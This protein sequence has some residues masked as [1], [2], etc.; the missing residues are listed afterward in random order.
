MLVCYLQHHC[1]GCA[2]DMDAMS[3]K[4]EDGVNDLIAIFKE[5]SATQSAD[6]KVEE[7]NTG[8]LIHVECKVLL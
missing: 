3:R 1:E 5:K 6:T 8:K 4:V 2:K 7:A